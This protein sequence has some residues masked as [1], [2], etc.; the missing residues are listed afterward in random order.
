MGKRFESCH[1]SKTERNTSVNRGSPQVPSIVGGRPVSIF[2]AQQQAT[3]RYPLLLEDLYCGPL[4]L[5]SSSVS[6]LAPQ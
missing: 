2:D 4:S 1:R 5:S 3:F 6:M